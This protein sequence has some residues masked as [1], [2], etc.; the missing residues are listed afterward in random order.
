M[1]MLLVNNGDA[2]VSRKH[3]TANWC[4]KVLILH[5][6]YSLIRKLKLVVNHYSCTT[7]EG[8]TLTSAQLS[9]YQSP[10]PLLPHALPA[11]RPHLHCSRIL[12]PYLPRYPLFIHHLH[13][14]AKI[15]SEPRFL[16]Y[17]ARAADHLWVFQQSVK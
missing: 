13:T 5:H 12:T 2:H 14:D 1:V 9:P 4:D 17:L 10:F 16:V 3:V 8:A 7:R 6:R 11:S 15:K